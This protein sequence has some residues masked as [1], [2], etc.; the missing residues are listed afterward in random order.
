[1]YE[2]AILEEKYFRVFQGA[3]NDFRLKARTDYKFD[4]ALDDFRISFDKDKAKSEFE[5][6]GFESL[7]EKI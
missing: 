1:M 4:K 3:Y 7:M 2:I 6:Y 5:K